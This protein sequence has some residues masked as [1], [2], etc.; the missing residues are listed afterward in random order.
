METINTL[1]EKYYSTEQLRQDI[2]EIEIKENDLL[3]IIREK[4]PYDLDKPLQ[5]YAQILSLEIAYRRSWPRRSST[6]LIEDS[7]L[8]IVFKIR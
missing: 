6:Y 4:L 7:S 1:F 5:N 3:K 8:P 2:R